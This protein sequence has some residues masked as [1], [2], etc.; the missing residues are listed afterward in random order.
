MHPYRCE[1]PFCHDR[2][3]IGESFP[4]AADRDGLHCIGGFGCAYTLTWAYLQTADWSW[5]RQ[6]RRQKRT[7]RREARKGL[8][9]LRRHMRMLA[10]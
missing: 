4:L 7:E 3:V 1:A 6:E 9:K 2:D 5:R 10:R 8:R